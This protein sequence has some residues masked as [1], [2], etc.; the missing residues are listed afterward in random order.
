[1]RIETAQVVAHRY[2][3][4]NRHHETQGAIMSFTKRFNRQIPDP[5]GD[6]LALNERTAV[7][8]MNNKAVV[9]K[10]GHRITAYYDQWPGMEKLKFIRDELIAVISDPR[11][12]PNP[13]WTSL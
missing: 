6:L 8:I 13:D 4:G 3:I 11:N 2:P 7:G 1:V 5:L 9:V 10:E 12:A